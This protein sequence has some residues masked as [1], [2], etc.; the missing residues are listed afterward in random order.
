MWVSNLR[1]RD[2]RFSDFNLRGD[3][4]KMIRE[5]WRKVFYFWLGENFGGRRSGGWEG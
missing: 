2:V 3:S 5:F 1:E 4:K